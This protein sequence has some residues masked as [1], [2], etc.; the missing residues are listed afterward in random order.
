MK[1][2]EVPDHPELKSPSD[3]LQR[4]EAGEVSE[5]AIPVEIDIRQRGPKAM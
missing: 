2:R 4:L 3:M 5:I 1:A